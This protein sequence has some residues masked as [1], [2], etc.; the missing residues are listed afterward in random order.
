MARLAALRFAWGF[1]SL[2]SPTP[3]LPMRLLLTMTDVNIQERGERREFG[4][5]K[6]QKV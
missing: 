3:V 6:A 5:K 4:H 2:A 1:A